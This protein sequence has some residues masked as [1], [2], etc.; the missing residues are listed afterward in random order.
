MTTEQKRIKEL[1]AQVDALKRIA[2][3]ERELAILRASTPYRVYPNPWWI[4]TTISWSNTTSL[5][6]Q[7]AVQMPMPYVGSTAVSGTVTKDTSGGAS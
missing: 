1:E 5:Q 3:L 2:E 4:P 6:P 7:R